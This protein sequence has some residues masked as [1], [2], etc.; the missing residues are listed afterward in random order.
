MSSP[1]AFNSFLENVQQY[2][3]LA[4]QMWT[5]TFVVFRL[6]G[7]SA[8]GSQIYG[9]E[10]ASFICDTKQ[11]GC[12][13]MCY[14]RFAPISHMKF[15]GFQILFIAT[16]VM[17]FYFYA[18]WQNGFI[19]KM[20]NLSKK[21][22]KLQAEVSDNPENEKLKLEL[23]KISN[24]RTSV[25]KKLGSTY[26]STGDRTKEKMKLTF[27]SSEAQSV[28]FTKKIKQAYILSCLSKFVMETFFVYLTYLVQTQQ[29]KAY[30]LEGFMV[31]ERY[32]CTHAGDYTEGGNSACG[33][34]DEII[35]WVSRP[36][37]K[38]IFLI[39]ML[40]VNGISL[41]LSLIEMLEICFV[42]G[43]GSKN[44]KSIQDYDRFN[45]N[46]DGTYTLLPGYETS[47]RK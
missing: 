29:S 26:G 45:Q 6:F 43:R 35:C 8:I 39:Y 21:Q 11:P 31:P 32:V 18:Q 40:F 30:G 7:Y 24:Q 10:E 16:P 46:S 25:G 5:I 13:Q 47:Q 23:M 19:K 1:A 42:S 20:Q 22:S 14:N 17:L 27:K 4:G 12:K 15:W 2:S 41:F 36:F 44:I 28:I 37:E 3:T 9:D 34:N 38:Q 33:Q